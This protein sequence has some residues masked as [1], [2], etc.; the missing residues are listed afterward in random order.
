MKTYNML[1]CRSMKTIYLD[2]SLISWYVCALMIHHASCSL[3]KMH[4]LVYFILG[5]QGMD[6]LS[7]LL[8]VTIFIVLTWVAIVIVCVLMAVIVTMLGRNMSWFTYSVNIVGLF[9]IP[10]IIA[11]IS[12]QEVLKHKVFQ[13][14]HISFFYFRQYNKN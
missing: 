9:I 4:M 11:V 14:R 8:Q 6:Y 1:L 13:V 10:G 2:N 3:Q 5:L 12:I 7:N